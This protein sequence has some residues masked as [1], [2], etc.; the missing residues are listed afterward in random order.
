MLGWVYIKQER[1]AEA[2]AA[3]EK[4]RKLDNTPWT[5]AQLAHAQARAG[6]RATAERLLAELRQRSNNE[7]IS[8]FAFVYVFLG[9][10]DKEQT[11][12]WLERSYEIQSADMI[13]LKV[14]PIF[15][16]LRS[17]PRFRDLL[18]R[19]NLSG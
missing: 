19:L 6:N 12:V 15:D 10:D 16:P 2:V 1:I 11:F 7:F 4:A 9:L 13:T 18:R 3:F 5:V 17:D 14:D 8:P